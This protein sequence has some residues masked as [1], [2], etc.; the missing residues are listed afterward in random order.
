VKRVVTI[1]PTSMQSGRACQVNAIDGRACRCDRV[2]RVCRYDHVEYVDTIE[3]SRACRC[4]RVKRVITIESSNRY[5]RIE[6][7]D[8][9]E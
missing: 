6:R 3:S 8:E 5:N 1:D 4:D 7:V 9:I 2:E